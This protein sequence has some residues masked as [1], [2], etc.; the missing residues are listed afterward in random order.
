M[1]NKLPGKKAILNSIFFIVTA[2]LIG[3]LAYRFIWNLDSFS[4]S[5]RALTWPLVGFICIVIFKSQIAERITAIVK[6][7]AGTF[8]TYMDPNR[9]KFES[10]ITS[11]EL[12]QVTDSNTNEYLTREETE[13]V[14]RISAAWGYEMAKIGFRNTPIPQ[15]TWS[16]RSPVINFGISELSQSSTTEKNL[17]IQKIQEVQEELDSL[18]VLDRSGTFSGFMPNRESVLKK[19]LDRLINQLRELDPSSTFLPRN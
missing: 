11:K 12:A 4:K 10:E 14:I 1:K 6:V 16:G 17:I 13:E 3:V 2:G 5:S 19:K 8:G 18:S 7:N 15:V 9:P